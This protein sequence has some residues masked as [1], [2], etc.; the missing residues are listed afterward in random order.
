[1]NI[2]H[3]NGS[4]FFYLVREHGAPILSLIKAA[5]S[6]LVHFKGLQRHLNVV[7]TLRNYI[8]ILLNIN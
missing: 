5:K 2:E 1:M 4:D 7:N 8:N 6:T 3:V